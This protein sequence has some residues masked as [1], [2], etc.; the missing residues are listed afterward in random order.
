MVAVLA[1]L[2]L[3]LGLVQFPTVN[4]FSLGLCSEDL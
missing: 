3:E 4:G 2:G 1:G